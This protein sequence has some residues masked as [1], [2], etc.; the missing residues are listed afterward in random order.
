MVGR[1]LTT[2]K[3]F[4]TQLSCRLVDKIRTF[5]GIVVGKDKSAVSLLV[6]NRYKLPAAWT[7]EEARLV[8]GLV[9]EVMLRNCVEH[10]PVYEFVSDATDEV[11]SAVVELNIPGMRVEE[12]SIREYYTDYPP[13]VNEKMLV[14]SGV[15]CIMGKVA[16][17]DC[18]ARKKIGDKPREK[19]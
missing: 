10:L 15:F 14:K 3:R 1:K 13:P 11:R 5:Y 2:E 7:D 17:Q 6:R 9:Y 8:I 12:T 4:H 18:G 16:P 19:R